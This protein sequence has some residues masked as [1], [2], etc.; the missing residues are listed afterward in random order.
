MGPDDRGLGCHRRRPRNHAGSYHAFQLTITPTTVTRTQDGYTTVEVNGGDI[1]RIRVTPGRGLAI[2]TA[3]SGPVLGIPQHLERF[4]ECRALLSQWY[5][6]EEA[7]RQLLMRMF[8]VVTAAH[9][10]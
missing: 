5:P 4:D 8:A 2:W 3:A 1:R 9:G 6:V 10:R 7:S